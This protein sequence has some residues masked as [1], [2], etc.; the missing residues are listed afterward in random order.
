M[1]AEVDAAVE[2][3][4]T[5]FREHVERYRQEIVVEPLAWRRRCK[6][7][8]ENFEWLLFCQ[9]HPLATPPRRPL[10]PHYPPPPPVR[11]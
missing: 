2:H 1:T 11:R 5:L 3:A 6:E 8:A 9:T 7:L 10:P 4:Y